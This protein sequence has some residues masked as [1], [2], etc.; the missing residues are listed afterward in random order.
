ML[1]YD[2]GIHQLKRWSQELLAYEFVC[3]HHP[4]RMMRDV[5]GVCR[6]IDPLIHRYLVDATVMR[7]K[8]IML[9]PFAYNFNI[10]SQYSNPRHVSKDDVSTAIETISTIPILSVLYNYPIRFSSPL[11]S[12][13][14]QNIFHL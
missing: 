1:E 2:G 9:R 11:Q 14:T 7:Y 8:G 4:N 12:M 3:I 13:P 10:F 5:D 6:H